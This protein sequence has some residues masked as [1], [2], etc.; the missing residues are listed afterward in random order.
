M[1]CSAIGAFISMGHSTVTGSE[2]A[3]ESAE[4]LPDRQPPHQHRLPSLGGRVAATGAALG[5]GW[6]FA[7]LWAASAISQVGSQFT[8]LVFPLLAAT[9]LDASPIAV[10]ALGAVGALPHLLFG[11]IAGAWVDRLRRRPILIAADIDRKSVV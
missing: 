1:S 6:D 3:G 2:A 10:G 4:P 9:T 8:L 7:H 11:F 5:Q